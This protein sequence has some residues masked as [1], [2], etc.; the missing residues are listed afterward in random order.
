[1]IPRRRLLASLAAWGALG[2]P[3]LA[4][5]PGAPRA[6]NDGDLLRFVE[7]MALTRQ[8]RD[9]IRRPARAA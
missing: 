3:V 1:M 8:G 9:G 2:G 4:A 6:L 7:L 5:R